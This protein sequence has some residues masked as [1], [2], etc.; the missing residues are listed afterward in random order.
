MLTPEW[1]DAA[2]ALPDDDTLVLIALEDREVWPAFRDYGRWCYSS[3]MPV[4]PASVTHWMHL[5][6]APRADVPNQQGQ[7]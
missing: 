5:P 1:I 2:A 4:E 3:G 6:A 7:Q